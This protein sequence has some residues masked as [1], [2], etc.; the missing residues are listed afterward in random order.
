LALPQ[1]QEQTTWH[2]A[3]LQMLSEHKLFFFQVRLYEGWFQ[4][5]PVYF[6]ARTVQSMPAAH[7]IGDKFCQPIGD[8]ASLSVE[9]MLAPTTVLRVLPGDGTNHI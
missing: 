2:H 3:L 6:F 8:S 4:A 9:N 5:L 1:T 7:V